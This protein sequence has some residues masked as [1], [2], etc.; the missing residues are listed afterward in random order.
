MT[1]DLS[2]CLYTGEC[3]LNATLSI[4]FMCLTYFLY[5]TFGIP[6]G[7]KYRRGYGAVGMVFISDL[8]LLK[9]CG[10]DSHR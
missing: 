3:F 6:T 9:W 5:V 4:D 8:S 1:W 2:I 10:C 7:I